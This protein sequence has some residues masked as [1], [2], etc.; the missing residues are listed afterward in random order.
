MAYPSITMTPAEIDRFLADTRHAVIATNSID[1]PPQ[2]S[3]VWYL[4]RDGNVYAGIDSGSAKFRN[5]RLDPRVSLCVDGAYP[6]ARYVVVYGTVECV[7]EGSSWRDEIIRAISVRY[8]ETSEEAER[9]LSDS[10][11]PDS[12]LLVIKPYKMFGKN[13]N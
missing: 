4:Y 10:P 8:H 1:G 11:G 9:S 7:E 3:P 13:Y 6:D 2:L 5:L 12:V